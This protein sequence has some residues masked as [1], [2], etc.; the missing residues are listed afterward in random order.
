MTARLQQIVARSGPL[1]LRGA[2][3]G[4]GIQLSELASHLGISR[5]AVSLLANHNIW[6]ATQDIGPGLA[7]F[8]D[9]HDLP[10]DSLEEEP[11]RANAAAPTPPPQT[12]ADNASNDEDP[13]M[14]LRKQSLTPQARRHFGLT[15]DPFADPASSEDVFL[16]PD[17]RYVRET[18]YQVARHGGFIA[19]IGE[20]GAGKSTLREELID[21]IRREEQAVVVVEPYVLAMEGTDAVGKTLRSQHISE[22]I[23]ASVAPLAK[24]KSSPEARFRQLHEALRDSSRAGHSHVLIIEEA[25]SLPLA[26]LKHLKRFRELKDGLR[27]LLSVILIGQPELS[28]KLSEHNPEVREVVQRIEIVTLAPLGP[29]LNEYL[30][31][32]F[33]RAGL[34]LDKVLERDAIPALREKLTPTRSEGSLLYPLALHNALAAA[35]NRAADLGVPLVTA[36]VVRGG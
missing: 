33:K 7:A 10:R 8:I 2:L 6:P 1:K 27:P 11:P 3:R 5:T 16:S 22:S 13:N 19:V 36:D 35:M 34:T 25:H 21:R 15:A 29:H 26:T 31:H 4:A 14:L 28:V 9:L 24:T 23:M 12:P 30:A 18:M 17:T 32:R 20:S